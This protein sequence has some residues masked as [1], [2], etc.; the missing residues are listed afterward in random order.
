MNLKM[1]KITSTAIRRIQL[2]LEDLKSPRILSTY[3]EEMEREIMQP[4]QDEVQTDVNQNWNLLKESIRNVANKT[5]K[6][7]KRKNKIWFNEECSRKV[8][9]RAQAR[10]AW[11]NNRENNELKENYYRTRKETQ[12]L[13]KQK[14]REHFNNILTE[15][16][17]DFQNHRSRQLHQKIPTKLISLISDCLD[18]TLCKI[19]MPNTNSD[20]FEVTSGLRQGDPIS[21]VLFNLM[22][23]RVDREFLKHNHRGLKMGE[24]SIT[25]MAYADDVILMAGSKA[26]VAEM[27]WNYYNIAKKV[28]LIISE[29]K[30]KYMCVDKRDRSTEPLTIHHLSFEKVEEFKYLGSLFNSE[31]RIA[32]EHQARTAAANRAYFSIQNILK[33]R[34]L[35]TNFKIRLYQCYIVPVLLYGSE[36]LTFR[37]ADEEK[38]LIFERKILRR[39]F[40]PVL[41]P[42]YHEWRILKNR[43]LE[44]KYPHADI[45]EVRISKLDMKSLL[46]Y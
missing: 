33:K 13:L 12:K 2:H 23:E 46:A 19:K 42:Q 10:L 30:T 3:I 5:L 7:R 26:E 40:G 4:V 38:L 31:N 18:K 11:L 34:S 9:E 15:A 35:S 1:K 25:R 24:K 32:Q 28:G 41:D 17:D 22:L 21:P 8:E 44:E 45:I 14:K 20:E 36:A 6:K 39:I 29:E 43:E 27:V 16:Q 37:K